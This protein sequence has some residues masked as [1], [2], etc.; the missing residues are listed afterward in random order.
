MTRS[1]ALTTVQSSWSSGKSGV[2]LGIQVYSPLLRA[3]RVDLAA[4]RI[5]CS[6]IR[7]IYKKI[8]RTILEMPV[9]V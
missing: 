4:E 1:W 8:Q 7:E 2:G 5:N 9:L 3:F 6:I